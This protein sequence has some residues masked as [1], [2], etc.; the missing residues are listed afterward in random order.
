MSGLS[1]RDAGVDIDKKG[2][3]LRDIGARVKTTFGPRVLH[4]LGSFGGMFA[5]R[6]PEYED[7]ILVASNDGVGTKVRTALKSG[8]PQGLGHDIVNHCVNDILVQSAEPLFFL[9][10]F[11]SAHLDP[12][13]FDEVLEGLVQACQACGAALLGGET[14][15]MPG[16]Y[17]PGE[18]DLVGCVVGIVDRA[19]VWPRDVTPGLALVGVRSDGLH[20]NGYSLVNRVLEPRQRGSEFHT[21]RLGRDPRRRVLPTAPQLPHARDGFARQYRRTRR[22]AHHRWGT[23]RQPAARLAQGCRRAR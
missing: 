13:V 6:F 2:S 14:A 10:Y 17:M 11:A 12:A 18:L 22:R 21:R 19:K 8:R 3:M 20:T 7:P 1:Y 15:E 5:G 23:P 9:D 4:D 16:T